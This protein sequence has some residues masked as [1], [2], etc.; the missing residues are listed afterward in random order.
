VAY[1]CGGHGARRPSHGKFTV[2]AGI[3]IKF[4]VNDTE[5]LPNNIGQ[6]VDRI[7]AGEA[8]PPA[9]ETVNAGQEID[10]YHL[11]S[12]KA[13]GY[14]NLGMSSRANSRYIS[15]PDKEIGLALST[16]CARVI[17]STPNAV[18]HWSACRAVEADS[19]VFG[20]S[21]PEYNGAL[22]VLASRVGPA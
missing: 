11:Y 9:V 5:S 17:S 12:S 15:T 16:I 7:L 10:D 21:K 4:Y 13:G 18:I 8:A 14:L 1:V 6:Q 22:G 2:P 3:T 19:D 20:W